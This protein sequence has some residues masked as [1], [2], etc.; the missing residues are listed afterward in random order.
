MNFATA[1]TGQGKST[2][3]PVKEADMAGAAYA[4]HISE[5]RRKDQGLYLTPVPVANFMAGQIAASGSAIR[6][7]DPAA[8]A[9]IL[10]C[11]AV[12]ALATRAT[13][14]KRI[15]VVA[16]EIDAGLIEILRNVLDH[17]KSWARSHGTEVTVKVC[18]SDFILDN[19]AAL[20]GMCGFLPHVRPRMLSMLLSRIRRISN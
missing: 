17:L 6:I 3:S 12:Q 16:Y 8:G 5:D 7:L 1:D 14:P 10:L 9:G 11:A 2:V 20:S 13:P 4:A 18:H 15:E 19:G